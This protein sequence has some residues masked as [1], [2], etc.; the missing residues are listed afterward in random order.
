MSR[1][2][3]QEDEDSRRGDAVAEAGKGHV[4][5]FDEGKGGG[6]PAE[7]EEKVGDNAGDGCDDDGRTVSTGSI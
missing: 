7:I 1:G 4:E 3:S 6:S 2:G 5:G